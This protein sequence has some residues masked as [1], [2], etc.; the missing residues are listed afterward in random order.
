MGLLEKAY[1]LIML[2]ILLFLFLPTFKG[3]LIHNHPVG[4]YNAG[5][6]FFWLFYSDYVAYK[7]DYNFAP[8]YIVGDLDNTRPL[9]PP[10]F[11]QISALTTKNLGIPMFDAQNLLIVLFLILIMY[12]FYFLI[13]RFNKKVAYLSFPFFILLLSSPFMLVAF[14]GLF[15]AITGILF[16]IT[17]VYLIDI[18][19]FKQKILL[20]IVLSAMFLSHTQRFVEFLI[21]IGFFM[22]LLTVNRSF[23]MSYVKKLLLSVVGSLILSFNYLLIFSNTLLKD[24]MKYLDFSMVKFQSPVG[25]SD[26]FFAGLKFFGIF[27]YFFIVGLIY[28]IYYLSKNMFKYI[29]PSTT[30]KSN[31]KSSFMI[32]TFFASKLFVSKA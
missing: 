26:Y 1:E 22:F 2:I 32:D 24:F 19:Y 10:L 23:K 30:T 25:G 13:Y 14:F 9:Y 27:K 21:F 3:S 16:L 29:I 15:A 6:S 11:P 20:C 4:F 18:F 5:D 8:S 28:S 12:L 17:G 31:I 7:D